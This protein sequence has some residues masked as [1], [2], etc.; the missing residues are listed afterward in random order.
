MSLI[1]LL[2]VK[3]LWKIIRE[4]QTNPVSINSKKDYS[5][6]GNLLVIS[7]SS[8]V[9]KI[10]INIDIITVGLNNINLF[11]LPKLVKLKRLK[12]SNIQQ[13]NILF[14]NNKLLTDLLLYKTTHLDMKDIPNI[15]TLKYLNI[16]KCGI[17]DKDLYMLREMYSIKCL[18]LYGLDNITNVGISYLQKLKIPKLELSDCKLLTNDIAPYINSI[19]VRNLTIKYIRSIDGNILYMLNYYC[20]TELYL[21]YISDRY[22]GALRRY[23]LNTLKLIGCSKYTLQKLNNMKIKTLILHGL[24]VQKSHNARFLITKELIE[25]FK[26]N[27]PKINFTYHDK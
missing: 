25:D 15:K 14:T 24:R 12:L 17:F 10:D 23:K 16:S 4:Y 8:C 5:I 26:K 18:K 2:P 19:K 22:L 6:I 27:N 20:I 21:T 9:N 13:E 3:D 7:L 1:E 11:N